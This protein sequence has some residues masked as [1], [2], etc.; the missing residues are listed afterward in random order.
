MQN[1]IKDIRYGIRMLTK[2]PGVSLVAVITLALGIGANAA[3][4]SGVSAFLMRPLP[5]PRA[6]ELIRPVEIA[7]DR[8]V[9]DEWSY[10]DFLD[11]RA[12]SSSFAGLAA[13]D[14]APAAIDA[15][16]QNDV[17]WGQV[18]SANYF[19]VIQIHPLLGRGFAPDEDKTVGGSP[20]LVLSHSLWQRRFASDPNIVGKTVRLNDRQYEII[21]VAPEYFTGTKFALAMDFWTP[22]SMAEDLRRSP[23]LLENRGS[24]QPIAGRVESARRRVRGP[25]RGTTRLAPAST[26]TLS[27]PHPSQAAGRRPRD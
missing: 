11:Y 8:G 4:F 23:K 7:E 26:D 10:P 6:H 12:Q 17:I 16:N 21:G 24:H 2:N 14:M 3:I 25:R 27:H 22:I 5:V 1:L 15:E 18:V 20:V 9:A 19:D 13:E